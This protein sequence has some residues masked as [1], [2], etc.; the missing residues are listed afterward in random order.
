MVE[1]LV[2]LLI[3]SHL[4]HLYPGLL[5]HLRLRMHVKQFV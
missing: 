4:M 2:W 1:V 3:A 5:Q